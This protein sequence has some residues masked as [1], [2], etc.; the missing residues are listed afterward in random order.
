[1]HVFVE[2]YTRPVVRKCNASVC[3]EIHVTRC[4][5]RGSNSN[6]MLPPPFT[7]PLFKVISH[8]VVDTYGVLPPSPWSAAGAGK[9]TLCHDKRMSESRV[10][11]TVGE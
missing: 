9:M 3:R 6:V 1:M 4:K 2:K 11:A 5:L 7:V 10:N 8:T